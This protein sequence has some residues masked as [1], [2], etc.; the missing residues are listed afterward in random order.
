MKLH[1]GI[2]LPDHEQHLVE[3]MDKSGEIV[4]GKGSYQ[5]RKLRAALEHVKNWRVAVDVGAHVGFWSM[6]LAERFSRVHCFEPHAEHRA[7]WEKNVRPSAPAMAFLYPCALG[8][9]SGK[10]ALEVPPGSSGGTHVSGAGEIT[11][12]TLDSFNLRDVDFLKIDVEGLELQVLQGA[13][14]T[15]KR[16]RPTVIVEQ[17]AHTPGGQKHLAGGGTPAVDFLLAMGAKQRAVL[18][19]DYIMGW[20]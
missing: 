20:E 8:A 2:W 14:D 9:A 12:R 10:V 13:I 3:W 17:K 15:L 4:N 6:H 7:C 19:G 18:S 11:M 16:C 5:I 1:Q